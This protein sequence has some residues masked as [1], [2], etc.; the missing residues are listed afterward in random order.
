V[1]AFTYILLVVIV[2]L[3]VPLAL[4]LRGRARTEAEKSALLSAQTIAAGIGRENVKVGQKLNHLVVAYATQL[5]GR[6]IVTNEDGIV[7]ADSQSDAVGNFYANP[8]RPEM[9]TALGMATTPD[10]QPIPPQPD[11]LLRYSTDLRAQ[12]LA[13]AAPILDEGRVYGAVRLTQDVTDVVNQ[14]RNV[15][16]GIAIVGLFGLL[17]GLIIAFGLAESLSRPLAKLAAAS[18][19]IGAGDLSARAGDIGGATEIRDLATSFDEMAG[20]VE[21]TV[22]SQREFVANAS[23]QLRTPLTGMK[24]RLESAA[25][26]TDDPDLTRQIAAADADVDRMAETVNRMLVMADEVE[27]GEATMVELRSLAEDAVARWQERAEHMDTFVAATGDPAHTLANPADVEQV[28][29][30]LIDNAL[31]HGS[32]PIEL[33]TGKEAGRVFLAVRDHGKGIPSEERARV[34][35]RFYRGKSAPSGGS[36]LGLAIAQEL[37]EKWGGSL[38]IIDAE[39]GGTRIEL[40]LR[41]ISDEPPSTN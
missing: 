15:T 39:G 12:L 26:Q 36:G 9:R 20:R 38:E 8:L 25:T 21:R 7:L 3:T 28:V 24:L 2:A 37:S 29:D 34:T 13:A 31:G 23:H 41:P 32:G 16:I 30:N 18:K 1:L 14:V 19:Q 27:R 10:G 6:V 17:A 22:R 11:S 35:E 4:N 33:T 5:G 40:R